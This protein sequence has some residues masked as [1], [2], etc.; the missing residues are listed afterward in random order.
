MMDMK[1]KQAF[2]KKKLEN[3]GR[4]ASVWCEERLIQSAACASYYQTRNQ[5]CR[6]RR[7]SPAGRPSIWR[8]IFTL[9]YVANTEASDASHVDSFPRL[10]DRA[11]RRC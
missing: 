2:I 4:S 6:P 3:D 7:A 11:R 8:T 1:L 10:L 9:R 5:R